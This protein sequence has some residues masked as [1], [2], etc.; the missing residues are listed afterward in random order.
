MNIRK[1]ILVGI[2]SLL[3]LVA[4]PT[5]TSEL[6]Q[7]TEREIFSH[8]TVVF[9]PDLRPVMVWTRQGLKLSLD[10]R[11]LGEQHI[12]ITGWE[13]KTIPVRFKA[14]TNHIVIPYCL[15]AV[16]YTVNHERLFTVFAM[17]NIIYD[18]R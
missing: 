9:T 4:I 11:T 16:E 3:T 15:F 10:M 1:I 18:I 6:T 8:A 14:Y 5:A 17:G 2:I 13:W 7:D 12:I